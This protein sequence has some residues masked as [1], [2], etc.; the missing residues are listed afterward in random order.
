MRRL[1]SRAV[2]VVVFLT[3]VSLVAVAAPSSHA[4]GPTHNPTLAVDV[5][6]PL[7][8][9]ASDLTVDY[10]IPGTDV[11]FA[12]VIAFIPPDWEITPGD[13]IPIGAP[14]GHLDS[15]ATLGLVNGACNTELP[16]PFDFLNATL[17]TS[18]V[19]SFLDTDA[20]TIPD[21]AED[22][23]GDGLKDAVDKWP[24]FLSRLYP[25]LEPIRRA[26]G[27]TDVAGQP[28]LLQFLVFEPGTTVIPGFPNDPALG[29]PSVTVLQNIGDPEADPMPGAI[30]DFC[31]PLTST[32]TSFGVVPASGGSAAGM[33]LL[34]NPAE[35]GT[36]RFS[37]ASFGLWDADGDGFEN[38]LDTCPFNP[39]VGNPKIPNSGDA[40]GDGLDAA[41]DPDDNTFNDD[42]DGDGY[43]NRQDNCPL[44]ANGQAQDN[45][46]DQDR[47]QIGDA[48]D[49]EELG[50]GPLA[51]D[52][53]FEGQF[54]LPTSD[55]EIVEQ[56]DR[57]ADTD[58]N[59]VVD[60]VDALQV[61]RFVAALVPFGACV[62]SAGDVDCN[63]VIDLV[64]A[65]QILR[66]VAALPVQ[67]QQPC[68]SIGDP[69]V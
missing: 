20:N 14:V 16:V 11:N 17:D 6:V 1:F 2:P 13:Q 51:P 66:F 69:I 43:V 62:Q 26:A 19:V 48:C 29:Y 42:Q 65:L 46:K 30:T 44:V 27:V 56:V 7:A 68:P 34:R 28:V 12:A 58:C 4:G 9:F 54:A 24:D 59:G 3:V 33:V 63:G 23:N 53:G 8:G 67:Q 39:N 49:T 22:K 10:S 41:C 35:P 32:N 5:A 38:L 61:L 21:F 25:G 55:V 18:Q 52:G 64:D 45:Q 37:V 60:L 36:K 40:D 57:L 15:V 50:N 47:D 31:T